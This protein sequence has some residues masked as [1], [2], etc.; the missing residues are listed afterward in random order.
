MLVPHPEE[1]TRLS[2]EYKDLRDSIAQP[3]NRL[4]RLDGNFSAE[5]P[6]SSFC[7]HDQ[8]PYVKQLFDEGKLLLLANTGVL[9]QYANK[10]NFGHVT[11]TQLFSHNSMQDE[12]DSLDP[13]NLH[14]GTGALG[15]LGDTLLEKG[16]RVGRTAV[17]TNPRN[18][19]GRLEAI[20]P[21]FTLDENGVTPLDAN[22]S[23][24]VMNSVMRQLNEGEEN[25]VF[26]EVWSTILNRSLN[27]TEKVYY[28]LNR[29]FETLTNFTENNLSERFRLVS[30]LIANRETREIDRDLFTVRFEG[31]DMHPEVHNSLNGKFLNINTA[32][33][34]LVEELKLLGVWEDVVLIQ[35]SD[36]GRTLTPNSGGGS[37]AYTMYFDCISFLLHRLD[38]H[39][40]SHTTIYLLVSDHGWGG[41]YIMTGGS[42]EGGRILGKYPDS[43]SRDGQLVLGRGRMIPTTAW[44][45]PFNAIF[46]WMGI[47]GSAELD[48]ILP[49]RG[50]FLD[51]LFSATDIF[52][53]Q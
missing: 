19:A 31:F 41:N 47:S 50:A 35:T 51:D 25:G 7:L 11:E 8:L 1:C 20:S 42:L 46:E 43:F 5:Q 48:A 26:G 33:R 45:S 13:K 18:L 4:L 16:Y 27:Q 34:D 39:R 22:L 40:K 21:V 6:C 38:F 37:G 29:D 17:E 24:P 30:Q 36:F 23:S 32:L 52:R 28:L 9:T 49:N 15:R 44:E 10:Q 53:G 12:V 2:Q 3:D 14:R